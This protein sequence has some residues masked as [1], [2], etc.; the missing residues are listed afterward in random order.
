VL[1]QEMLQGLGV[2]VNRRQAERCRA[3][4]S[5]N[6]PH[7]HTPDNNHQA[8]RGCSTPTTLPHPYIGWMKTPYRPNPAPPRPHGM[9][10]TTIIPTTMMV[11]VKYNAT[12]PLSN[13]KT[14]AKQG[15]EGGKRVS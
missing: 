5:C 7:T 12:F 1:Q 2:E 8:H 15:Q 13:Y 6:P 10:N 9:L 11:Q 4:R 14:T 3:A